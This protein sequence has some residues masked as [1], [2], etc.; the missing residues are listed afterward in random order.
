MSQE[1]ELQASNITLDETFERLVAMTIQTNLVA[2]DK[3]M[4]ALDKAPVSYAVA[5]T[6]VGSIGERMNRAVHEV[7]LTL[8]PRSQQV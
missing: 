8:S 2:L 5:A 4:T 7:G 6:R 1:R 3:T